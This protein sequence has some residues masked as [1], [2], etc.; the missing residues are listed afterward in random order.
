MSRSIVVVTEAEYRRA[1][2][3]FAEAS[4][5]ACVA[6]PR[7]EHALVTAIRERGARHAVVGPLPYRDALYAALPHGG[8]L[9]RFGVGHDG[10]DKAMASRSGVLCTNTPG[11]LDQSVAELTML[12]VSAAARHLTTMAAQM[13]R[14]DWTP[15]Q[16]V[17]LQGK[18]LAIIGCG[19]IGRTTARIASLGFGMRVIGFG[20]RAATSAAAAESGFAT[21]TDDFAAA[22][23]DADYVSLHIPATPENA[24]FLA[25]ERL[26]MLRTEA[27]L[28]NTARGAVVNERDLFDAL[29]E[30][31]IA[32]AALDVFDREPYV[33]ADP[34]RDLRTLP[35]VILIPHVGSNTREANRRMAERALHNIVAAEAGNFAAMDL[36][37]PEALRITNP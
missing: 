17:E 33:P 9:A 31:R 13:R 14:G 4:A 28:I 2:S 24:H 6:A 5:V 15:I 35:S 32:G 8:V 34:S 19:R 7:E 3:V 11:V 12:L 20:R 26:S 21:I 10:I 1:E 25:R 18:T 23:G 29:V 36:L 16:G 37:N 27:W 22:V 30:G